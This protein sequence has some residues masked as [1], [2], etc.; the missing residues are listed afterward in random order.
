MNERG[1]LEKYS[2]THF[3]SEGGRMCFYYINYAIIHAYSRVK[4]LWLPVVGAM[5]NTKNHRTRWYLT[6]EDD[7]AC[8]RLL[9]KIKKNPNLL[10]KAEKDIA[11]LRNSIAERLTSIE[12]HSFTKGELEKLVAYF[13]NQLEELFLIASF[14][15]H[16]DRGVLLQLRTIFVSPDADRFISA[17]SFSERLTTTLEEELALLG[18]AKALSQKKI[19]LNSPEADEYITIV[20]EKYCWMSCGYYKEKPRGKEDYRTILQDFITQDPQVLIEKFHTKVQEAMERKK[21]VIKNL[22]KEEQRVVQIAGEITYLKD[23]F[24]EAVNKSIYHGEAIYHEVSLRT[25]EDISFLKDL[26]S[27]EL[28]QIIGGEDVNRDFIAERKKQYILISHNKNFRI[29]IG[30]DAE[31]FERRYLQ[32]HKREGIALR[33]RSAVSGVARGKVRVILSAEDFHKFRKDEVLVALNTSP[34]YVVV[35]KKA[36]A[37]LTEEGGISSH[38]SVVSRELGI[39][40]I[41]GIPEI[42]DILKDGMIVEVDADQG[43]VK[44]LKSR[45]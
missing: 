32:S 33:G 27:E 37:I 3:Y 16:L 23:K 24:K 7:Q 29:F 28:V 18:I 12:I 2:K 6:T 39:P 15:R 34:D 35:M 5:V 36:G 1:S 25:K 40:S 42:T 8:T 19:V 31:E 14:I 22:S 10:G 9:N 43:V 13:F 20:Q 4:A 41:V 30:E 38:A 26:S 21:N 17:V 11:L 45:G 44:I